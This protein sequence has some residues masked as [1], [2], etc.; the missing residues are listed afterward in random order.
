MAFGV[1]QKRILLSKNLM[2]AIRVEHGLSI[3]D[4]IID[5]S[6]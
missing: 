6:Y 2:K 1:A 5:V 4:A 3:K